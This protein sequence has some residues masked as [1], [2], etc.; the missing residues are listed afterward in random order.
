MKTE[1]IAALEPDVVANQPPILED[2]D[3]LALD[4]ALRDAMQREGGAWIAERASALS[5]RIGDAKTQKLADLANRYIPVLHTHDRFGNRI[6][7]VEYH[8]AYHELMRMGVEAGCHALPWQEP[9]PG[10]HVAR[11][12]L[13]I[14]RAQAEEGSGCPITMTF[15]VV[16]SL[17]LQPDV[18]AEWEPRIVKPRYDESFAPADRKEGVI[19]G[20]A[21][22]ERQGGSDVRA[23]TSRALPFGSGGPGAEYELRG[24]KWFCSAPMS[25]A[26]LTLARTEKGLSCFLLPRFRPD[27][28]RNALRINRLKDK[29]GNKSNASSEIEFHGAW[30][31]MVGEEG[32]GVAT[33]IEMVRHTRLDCVFGSSASMRAAFSQAAHHAC[34]R[35]AFS[36]RLVDQPLMRNVLADL[37]VESEAATRMALRLAKW[38]DDSDKDPIAAK[39]ARIGTAIAKYWVTKRNPG[40]VSEALECIGG[41]GFIE[42]SPMPRLYRD[43]PINSLWEGTGNVQCLDV[44]RAAHKDPASLEAVVEELRRQAGQNASFD[45][46]LRKL[47]GELTN[48]RDL[49]RRAR[50]LVEWLATALQAAVLLESGASPV[51]EAFC[52]SRLAG[53]NGLAYGTLP[54]GVDTRAIVQRAWP[55]AR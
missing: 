50:R 54:D 12:V 6:D 18:A 34:H 33:I 32:R 38:F 3:P 22:T 52:D 2:H 45:R 39:L 1:E 42:E 4:E 13:C 17:R 16:P 15:A 9:K 37:A 26:F 24:H 43:S 48:R 20:M 5:K 55:D 28:S 19:F 31:R 25:D 10:A 47:E 8:P 7:E 36:R 35:Y 30:A 21:L 41:N 53:D 14:L 44:L 27:G 11:G 49:E 29:M 40:F 46:H 51:A 23:N